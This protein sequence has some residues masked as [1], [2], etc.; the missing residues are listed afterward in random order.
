MEKLTYSVALEAPFATFVMKFN[1]VSDPLLNVGSLNVGVV[2][3]K[4]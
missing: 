3:Q 2:V 4:N 1:L